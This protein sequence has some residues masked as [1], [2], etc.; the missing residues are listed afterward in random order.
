MV[1][2][3]PANSGYARD[4]VS[5]PGSE[6][7]RIGNGNPLQYSW[8]FPWTE[9]PGGVA[10]S[11]TK[12]S[13]ECMRT[14]ARTHAYTHTHTHTHT[15]PLPPIFL[16]TKGVL[17]KY[18]AIKGKHGSALLTISHYYNSHRNI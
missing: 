7:P 5:M 12:L 15:L 3:L 18:L 6:D 9:E 11:Q 8:K 14:R 4:L 1:K 2:K 10:K 16:E 13:N 17:D